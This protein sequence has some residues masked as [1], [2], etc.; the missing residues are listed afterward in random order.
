MN[1]DLTTARTLIADMSVARWANALLRWPELVPAT[2]VA[3][4][5][6]VSVLWNTHAG[7]SWTPPLRPLSLLLAIAAFVGVAVLFSTLWPQPVL[8]EIATYFGLWPLLLIFGVRLNYLAATLDFPLQDAFLTRADAFL[9]FDWRSWASTLW[10]NPLVIDPLIAAYSSHIFQSLI[11]VC[12]FAIWGPRGRNRELLIAIAIAALGTV[13]IFA[14]L[15]AFGPNR[16]YGIASNWDPVLT[17][18]RAGSLAPQPYV[19]LVTFPSYHASMAVIFAT[20]MRGYRAGFALS[21]LFNGL[22]IVSTVPLGYHYLV[23]VIAGCAIGFT[24]NYFTI[25][26]LERA[27]RFASQAH[28]LG[29][30]NGWASPVIGKS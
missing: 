26:F 2:L 3:A 1:E 20:S 12:V 17:A 9:G 13:A 4:I 6:L 15:P 19:G 11:L 14:V 16:A 24:A 30:R 28:E 18:L 7:L 21:I 22:M 27:N 23:D 29:Q 8:V 5:V 25:R 10:A